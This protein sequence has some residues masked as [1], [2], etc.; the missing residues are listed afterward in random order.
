MR[1][2][3]A[4]S[5]AT[6]RQRPPVGGRRAGEAQPRA[7]RAASD[8]AQT[9]SSGAHNLLKQSIALGLTSGGTHLRGVV[10]VITR[11]LVVRGKERVGG[12]SPEAQSYIHAVAEIQ[13]QLECVAETT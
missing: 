7:S 6:Q 10:R 1:P 5:E 8:G 13:A 4:H 2:D 3:G 12:I 11:V 9:A